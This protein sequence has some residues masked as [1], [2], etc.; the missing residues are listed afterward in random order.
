MLSQQR[1]MRRRIMRG[2]NMR[3]RKATT[4]YW[5]SKEIALEMFSCKIEEQKNT[6]HGGQG[7][8]YKTL[9][10]IFISV[11]TVFLTF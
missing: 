5:C 9:F 3:G 10:F 1:Q 6:R 11:F 4:C 2:S 7:L 8:I